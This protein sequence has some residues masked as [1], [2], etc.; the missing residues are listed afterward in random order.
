MD[1]QAAKDTLLA[2]LVRSRPNGY[3]DPLGKKERGG[4]VYKRDDGTVFLL[5]TVT[6]LETDCGYIVPAGAPP[7]ITGAR[8]IGVYHTHPSIAGERLFGCGQKPGFTVWASRDK[9]HGGGSD[10]DWNQAAEAG[11]PNWVIDL[12]WNVAR[13][14]PTTPASQR[15]ANP[16]RWK[17]DS[18]KCAQR[19]I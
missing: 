8:P 19:S 11:L 14:D 15:G 10:P 6:G 12:D 13:L 1:S 16:N 18:N 3:S 4:Y 2:E 7:T 17:L 9:R 5:P